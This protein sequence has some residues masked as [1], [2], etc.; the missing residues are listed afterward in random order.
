[1][2]PAEPF[3]SLAGAT[4]VVTGGARG[5]GLQI[6]TTLQAVGMTAVLVDRDG[7]ELDRAVERLAQSGRAAGLTADLSAS[8]ASEAGG[9]AEIGGVLAGL[10][11]LAVWVNNA[12]VVSH[13]AAEDVDVEEFERVIRDN[14][15]SALR[16]CQ[17]AF[18]HMR[19]G[20]GD[21]A[22]VNITSLVVDKVLPD[23]LSYAASKAA[24]Q[25][26]TRYAAQEWGRHGI[27]VNAISPGYVDT[28]L[29]QWADDDPRTQTKRQTLGTIALRRAGS[30]DDI[31]NAVLFLCSPLSA[32]VTGHILQV[33][34]G[35]HLL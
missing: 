3:A 12:G 2:K 6:A 13:Q 8:G 11:P 18:Q 26:V 20:S 7:A 25:S 9:L 21:R 16:G 19:A 35:W 24:L 23:R 29:T 1:M 15:A 31:A 28:R 33:D 14:T 27:R 5:I 22:I 4:A 10:P 17:T 32:Y 34:G 30:V